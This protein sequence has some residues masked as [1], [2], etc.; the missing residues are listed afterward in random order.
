MKKISV[1]T[2][3]ALVMSLIF[4]SCSKEGPQGSAGTAGAVGPAGP[5]G[6]TGPIGP[7]GNP[8]N[9]L[10]KI[11]DVTIS[12][13]TPGTTAAS[14]FHR[15]SAL[16]AEITNNIMLGGGVIA[17]FNKGG[18][19]VGMPLISL[20]AGYNLI[21]SI[22]LNTFN[23]EFNIATATTYSNSLNFRLII[24]PGALGARS[25]NGSGYT[26]EQLQKMNYEDACA[27]LNIKP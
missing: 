27:A 5:A 24:I 17:Y 21:H 25:A 4:V 23:V 19:L 9:N 10:I 11:K 7:T 12:N 6:P 15:G 8:G 14:K 2:I 16:V 18:S 22:A 26:L 13:W 20:E 3:I 1:L